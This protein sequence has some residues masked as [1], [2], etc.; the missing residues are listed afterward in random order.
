VSA[1]K[2]GSTVLL[3]VVAML[4]ESRALWGEREQV[5]QLVLIW[6]CRVGNEYCQYRGNYSLFSYT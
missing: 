5:Q 3:L 1:D 4:G 6:I 2:R